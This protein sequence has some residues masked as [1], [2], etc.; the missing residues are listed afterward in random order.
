MRVVV[1]GGAGFIGSTL[2]DELLARGEEVH[3]VDDLSAGKREQVA[4]AAALHVLDIREPLADA[5]AD[6]RPE[7]VF[8]LAAQVDVRVS[9]ADATGDARTNVLGTVNVLEFARVH[10][11]QVVFASTGGAIYGECDERPARENDERRPLSPYGTSKLAGEEYLATWNRLYGTRHVALRLG[12]VYGPRQDP[13]GEAG[14]VAIFLSRIAEGRS[15]TIFGDGAQTR[16]Y[17]FV[18]DVVRAFVAAVGAG[19][20]VFNV[21]TGIETSVLELWEASREAT[22]IDAEVVHDPPR[23]GELAR[24]CLDPSRAREELGWRAE[25]PLAE[26]LR[27]TWEW[28]R[29]E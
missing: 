9:V 29:E 22:G 10:D 7:V 18:G 15:G 12:N 14:V 25:V 23:L 17:L 19:G 8:H 5:L 1:T 2:V 16:D 11:A 3:V 4:P 13:H 24:S 20:G 21:G 6:V 27:R 26:G 28:I